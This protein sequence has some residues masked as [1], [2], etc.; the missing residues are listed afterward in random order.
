MGVNLSGSRLLEVVARESNHFTVSID[1]SKYMHD[2]L[3]KFNRF[4]KAVCFPREKKIY[5]HNLIRRRGGL[6]V[7]LNRNQSSLKDAYRVMIEKPTISGL[8]ELVRLGDVAFAVSELSRLVSDS[9]SAHRFFI[10]DFDTPCN[11]V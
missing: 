3:D 9:G 4:Q 6:Q 11:G 2:F 7:A 1:K 10:R 5:G 8:L